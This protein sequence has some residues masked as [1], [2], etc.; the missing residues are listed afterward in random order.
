[1]T[2]RRSLSSAMDVTPEKLAFIQGVQPG[3][4]HVAESTPQKHAQVAMQRAGSPRSSKPSAKE[5]ERPRSEEVILD[6]ALVPL[7]TRLQPTT[8]AALR[9]AYLEQKLHRRTPDTQ[10]EIIE[11]ALQGW[12]KKEGFL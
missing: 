1:M 8:A 4:L 11:A 5:Y 9:R 2:E 10:Q 12:L 7:T 6:H 3:A